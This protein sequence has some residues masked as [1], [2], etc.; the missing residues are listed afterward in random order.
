MFLRAS[1]PTGRFATPSEFICPRGGSGVAS[2]GVIRAEIL[3]E[4]PPR[5]TAAHHTHWLTSGRL[6]ALEPSGSSSAP[7]QNSRAGGEGCAH[8]A[9]RS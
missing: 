4:S 9:Q 2:L 1:S 5:S 7:L 8:F 3:P 6:P